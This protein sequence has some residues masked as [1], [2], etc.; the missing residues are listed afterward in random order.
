M[1]QDKKDT[2][3]IDIDDEIT[4]IVDKLQNSSAKIV[5]LVLPKRATALQSIVNMKLLKRAAADNGKNVVL[6]TSESGLLPLAGAT[7]MYVAK[8]LQSKPEIPNAPDSPE[9]DVEEV[10]EVEPTAEPLNPDTPIGE[11]A[12]AGASEDTVQLDNSSK[13]KKPKKTKSK[14]NKVPNFEKFRLKLL[15]IVGGV[16]MLIGFWVVAAFVLPKATITIGAETSSE[17][18]SFEFTASPSQVEFNPATRIVPSK[19]AEK[20]VQES[21]SAPATGQRDMGTKA[22]GSVTIRNCGS[23]PITIPAGTGVSSNNLTFLTNTSI[24]LDSGNYTP[25]PGSVCRETGS[26]VGSVK[27]T[28]QNNGDQYNL[29]AG[30]TYSVAGYG[31]SVTGVGTAMT[32]GSSRVVKVVSQ[33]DISS[34]QGELDINEDSIR[35]DLQRELTAQGFYPL[36]VTF[37]TNDATT[38]INPELDQEGNEVTVTYTAT[39]VMAGVQREDLEGLIRNSLGDSFDSDK[40]EIQDYGLD[41][42]RI[43]VRGTSPGGGLTIAIDTTVTIGPNINEEQLYA[44][45]AGKK[46][47]EAENIIRSLPDVKDVDIDLSPFWVNKIPKDSRVKFVIEKAN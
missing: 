36:E 45:I 6:I 3:Y 42:A 31:S 5:A 40:Q 46:H 7:G 12:G 38:T 16:L 13:P 8:N 23:E 17:Q 4:T 34:A 44:Q 39:Y 10:A 22:T 41:S 9:P 35:A 2:I 33:Q 11:L 29:A 26:H 21:K 43:T 20:K 28:A 24:S 47:G 14:K 1:A 30:S 37:A 19:N 18:T 25:P 15:L 32:G 27:V